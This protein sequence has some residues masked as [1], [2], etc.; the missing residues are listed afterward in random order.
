MSRALR[1]LLAAAMLSGSIMS[2]SAA[3]NAPLARG[4]AITDPD[5]LRRLDRSGAL[6]I[7]RLL[8]PERNAN[9]PLTSDLLFTSLSQLKEIPPA[10]DAEFD[11]Y[12]AR[13]RRASPSET[14]G[15][16][17]GFD[18]QLFDRA[19][20]KSAARLAKPRRAASR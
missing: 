4:T 10:I 13:H 3:E 7:S 18:V 12:I 2:L 15:V 16:G 5:L 17:E 19:A 11:R 20:L 14:I 9:A 1:I 6:S 8:Q